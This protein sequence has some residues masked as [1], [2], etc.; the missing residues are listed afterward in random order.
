MQRLPLYFIVLGKHTIDLFLQKLQG[1]LCLIPIGQIFSWLMNPKESN[2]EIVH[3][4][5]KG[6]FINLIV[7]FL[8]KER[9]GLSNFLELA[10]ELCAYFIDTDSWWIKAA[11]FVV[12]DGYPFC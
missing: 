3:N 7:E 9:V 11:K 5:L 2:I 10:W 1:F 12:E 4:P 6:G 8:L